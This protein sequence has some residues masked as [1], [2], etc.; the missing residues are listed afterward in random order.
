MATTYDGL[1]IS[2]TP[3]FGASIVVSCFIDGHRRYLL[4]HR[5]HEGPNY[6]GDWAWTPPAGSRFP[7]ESVDACAA[8][9]LAEETGLSGVLR[10]IPDS[11]HD[12]ALFALDLEIQ[13]EIRLDQEHDRYEWVSLADARLRCRPDA[14]VNGLNLV[15]STH[16]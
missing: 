8:R 1:P 13:P 15:A 14:I 2:R 12:W 5:A 4:L 10:A 11:D 6:E 16:L 9:E 7:G 3:P